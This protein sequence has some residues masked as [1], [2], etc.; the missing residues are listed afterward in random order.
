MADP[1]V[2]G[3]GSYIYGT[4]FATMQILSGAASAALTGGT[5]AIGAIPVLLQGALRPSRARA[6]RTTA[7]EQG[8]RRGFDLHP[9]ACL[10]KTRPKFARIRSRYGRRFHSS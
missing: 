1:R 6:T 2:Y 10:A 8:A 4:A 3:S 9:H 5:V 7:H